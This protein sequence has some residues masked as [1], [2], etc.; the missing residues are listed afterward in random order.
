MPQ[1]VEAPPAATAVKPWQWFAAAVL[2]ALGLAL[3][4][5][6]ADLFHLRPREHPEAG[7]YTARAA[8]LLLMD[9]LSSYAGAADLAARF[10]AAGLAWSSRRL[11]RPPDRRYPPRALETLSVARYRHLG[12][13]GRLTLELF[14]DRLYEI[15][16]EPDDAAA[17][18]RALKQAE[19]QLQRDRNARWERVDGDLRLASNVEFASSPVGLSLRTRPY[20][21]WQD[22]RLLRE[23]DEWDRR[24]GSIPY[25]AR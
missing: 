5:Y 12:V 14:N 1:Q 20:V 19:P 6:V 8:P 17:M 18:A 21:I 4:V 13:E 10:D 9:G 2:A 24:F 22:L 15:G 25:S 11:A 16:F 23:R 3:L 7:R